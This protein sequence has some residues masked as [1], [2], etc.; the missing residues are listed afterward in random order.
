MNVAFGDAEANCAAI[1]EF[2]Q[3]DAA[4]GVDLA[5]CPECALSGY[6]VNSRAEAQQIAI[7]VSH[8]ALL[9]LT[10]AVHET[11]VGLVV[12]FAEQEGQFLYNSAAIIFPGNS[13]QVFRKVHLPCIGY[14]RFA[15]AGSELRTFDSPWGRLGILICFDM[16][17]PEATRTLA[18]QGADLILLPTNWPEG[19]ET[20][21]NHICIARAAENRV[22]FAACNRTG[23]ENGF[24]FI[25]QSKII[26]VTGNVLARAD[27]APETLT[28]DLDISLARTKRTI[29]RPEEYEIDVMG[30]RQP[31]LYSHLSEP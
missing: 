24:T 28:A 10:D 17:P 16:R 11:K 29:I 14:D 8:P 30:C 4:S 7:P 27:T 18:L 15:T 20:S 1:V 9:R 12:G 19:A 23:S 22:F 5:L 3:Q 26:G 31:R 13:V 21:A 6:A 2:L 25:G